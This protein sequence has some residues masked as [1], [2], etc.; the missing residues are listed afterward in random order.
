MSL[1]HAALR[2]A[3]LLFLPLTLAAQETVS[4]SST[5]PA[6]A[7]TLFLDCNVEG[8]DYDYLRTELTW[9]SYVRD[10]G[11][12]QVQVIATSLG[13]GGGG[14]VVTLQ[15]LGLKEFKGI[16]EE[17]KYSV[18]QGATSDESRA[19]FTRALKVGL[20]R[21][22]LRTP[23]GRNLEVSFR[24][25]ASPAPVQPTT[26][27]WNFWVFSLGFNGYMNG[28]SQSK[29]H[30][31]GG[32]LSANRTTADWKINLGISGDYEASSYDLGDDGVYRSVSHSYEG[33]GLVVRSLGR[34]TSLGATFG[35]SSSTNQNIDL[36]LK[37]APTVEFD[38]LDYKDYSR[39]R[40][41]LSYSLGWNWFDYTDT[42]IYNKVRETAMAQS[43]SL[44][45]AVQQ[46]WGSANL[47]L[48]ASNYL[49]DFHKYRFGVGGG[50]SIRLAKGLSLSYFFNFSR[51]HDQIALPKAGAT[52]QEVLLRLK[53]LRTS[54]QYFGNI[55]LSYTF[56]SVLNNVVNPRMGSG[57]GAREMM[58][59]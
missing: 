13:S 22:V 25:G 12:A 34:R 16:D 17:I 40:L 9:V 3:L 30:S 14:S 55:G 11:A 31:F 35:G 48:N 28:E 6:T 52:D 2:A 33:D 10:Q 42:T 8:C 27:P 51:V 44:S 54:Y 59:F 32:N 36:S 45:Y 50:M 21:Y 58:M 26:D 39:K 47:G 7:L 56:G 18:P 4:P 41:I 37:L 20:A 23:Q 15:F 19:E 43:A 1:R 53:E 46:K 38:F 24:G 5:G 29:S 57:G 49:A